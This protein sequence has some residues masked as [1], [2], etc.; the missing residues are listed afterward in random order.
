MDN[1]PYED[2]HHIVGNHNVSLCE[3]VLCVKNCMGGTH[4]DVITLQRASR[5]EQHAGFL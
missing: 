5:G 2:A 3:D 1:Y 4:I